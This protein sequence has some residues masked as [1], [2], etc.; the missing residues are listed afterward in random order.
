[1]R[2]FLSSAY[3][4]QGI[5]MFTVVFALGQVF[6]PLITGK[7]LDLGASS[8]SSL[9]VSAIFLGVAAMAAYRQPNRVSSD[10]A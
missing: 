5:A 4:T 6:G 2:V 10:V 1:M 9:G 7:I 8:G 3:W